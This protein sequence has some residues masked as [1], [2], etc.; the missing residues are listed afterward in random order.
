MLKH[1][2]PYAVSCSRFFFLLPDYS[3]VRREKLLLAD[4]PLAGDVDFIVTSTDRKTVG[5]D[6]DDDNDDYGYDESDQ[7]LSHI[8][9]LLGKRV[10]FR[11]SLLLTVL[12]DT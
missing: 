3:C 11:L 7:I 8:A 5:G 12:P 1:P 2:K 6:N 9:F 4:P 10:R